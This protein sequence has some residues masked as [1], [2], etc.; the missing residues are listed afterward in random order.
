LAG[1]LGLG[2][3]GGNQLAGLH[4]DA[5]EGLAVARTAGVAAVGGWSHP[6]ILPGPPRSCHR[7]ERTS[8]TLLLIAMGVPLAGIPGAILG[9]I[10]SPFA[11]NAI[12]SN[13]STFASESTTQ[14]GLAVNEVN[15][16]LG[17]LTRIFLAVPR[18]RPENAALAPD[19]WLY[20]ISVGPGGAT[21]QDPVAVSRAVECTSAAAARPPGDVDIATCK[22]ASLGHPNPKG[23][24]AYL[25]AVQPFL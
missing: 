3:A 19:P 8:L 16:D 13:S 6:A 11:K 7:K 18:F 25:D 22:V 23:G 17:G 20:G 1:D 12:V 4:A 9:G 5:F 15:A 21:A 2:V 24:R 14:L 10:L